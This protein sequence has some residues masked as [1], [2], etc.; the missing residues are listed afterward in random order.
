MQPKYKQVSRSLGKSLSFGSFSGRQAI[1]LGS[2]F[3]LGFFLT[4]LLGFPTSTSIAVAV[5]T[6]L[7][8]AFLSGTKPYK[9]WSNIYPLTPFWVKGQARYISPVKKDRLKSKKVKVA[10]RDKAKFLHPLEDSLELITVC[11]IE[12]GDFTISGFILGGNKDTKLSKLTIKFGFNCHGLNPVQASTEE[13]AALSRNL[14]EGFKNIFDSTF[15]ISWSSFCTYSDTKKNLQGRITNPVSVESEYLDNANFARIQELA[16]E[17]KRK[18]VKLNVYTTFTPQLQEEKKKDLTERI[19]ENLGLFWLKR[20]ENKGREINEKRLKDVLKQAAKAAKRHLQILE[21]MGL[22]PTPMSHDELWDNLCSKFGTN[23]IPLPHILILDDKGLREE[24]RKEGRY[25]KSLASIIGD[26]IHATSKLLKNGTPFA[27]RRFVYLAGKKKYVAV[28]VLEEKPA[29]FLGDKGQIQNLWSIFSR[30]AVYDTELITEINPADSNLVRLAQQLLTKNSLSKDFQA[31]E[32]GTVEVAAQVNTEDSLDAQKRLFTG[33][34][35]LNTSVVILVYRNT[36]EELDEAC[37]YVCGLIGQPAKLEREEQYAWFLW[38]Q[39]LGIRREPLLS[40]PYYRRL[41]FFASE[42]SGV[43]NLTQVAKADNRGFELIA[44]QSNSP[45]FINFEKPKNMLV[46]GTTGSGKSLLVASMIAECLAEDM[47]FLIIDLPNDDGIGSFGD[48]TTFFNGSYFDISRESN[49]LLQ[50]PDLSSIRS[51]EE[52]ARRKQAYRNDV[53]LIIT[54]LV[55]SS[56]SL[57][58]FLVQTIESLIPLGMKAFYEDSAIQARFE[59]ASIAGLGSSAW[60]D[61]P[62][63]VDLLEFFSTKYITLGYEDEFVE[64]ALNHIRLRLQYWLASS[65]GKAIGFPST[66]NTD[67]K[68]ITFALTN[69]QSEKEAEI[70]GLSAYMAASRQSLSSQNSAFFMDEASVLLKFVSLSRLVGRKCATARKQG[71]RVILAGQDADSIARSEAGEQILQNMPL[72]LIGRIVPG[73]SQSYVDTLGIPKSII[74]ENESFEPNV[75]ES[76]TRWLLDYQNTYIHCR[77]YP[78]YPILALTA[79]S[80]EEQAT[81]NQFKARYKDKFDWLTQYYRYYKNSLKNGG[82]I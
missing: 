12:L 82:N 65:I 19:F 57:E 79:N 24:F 38:L 52:K 32:K 67:A 49:N 21:E 77:Y 20:L 23:R 41:M 42:V 56:H 14:E 15:T 48:L 80:R 71:S 60:N 62:T 44:H 66:F 8:C 2:V 5:W 72:R 63:L 81:R 13:F 53:I 61:S 22:K 64:K 68:L 40:T 46:L 69:I 10:R 7:T 37:S 16:G 4:S 76:Y 73:A 27:D 34:M 18:Q 39:T 51:E 3:S 54:Q 31:R 33:D 43:C 17:K 58:G 29:G 35:P 1:I 28:L 47:S 9:Y 25:T 55:L 45:V 11:R 50:P 70:L 75:R 78:S 6:G 74:T 59:A 36:P 30:E 26:E